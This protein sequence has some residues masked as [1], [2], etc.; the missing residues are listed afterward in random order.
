[1]GKLTRYMP[2]K[3]SV[4]HSPS[5]ADMIAH[6]DGEWYKRE[7]VDALFSLPPAIDRE[8]EI[9]EIL[10][11]LRRRVAFKP[12]ADHSASVGDAAKRIAALSRPVD[13]M[14]RVPTLDS[15]QRACSNWYCFVDLQGGDCGPK[16]L[17]N[18]CYEF[19]T[20][21]LSGNT[22]EETNDD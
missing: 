9:I 15:V 2:Y 3:R 18:H 8:R 16:A 19:I 21:A 6:E 12:S 1:M 7:E 17:V 13:T 20:R 22:E 4:P 10:W 11:E 14:E 5:R